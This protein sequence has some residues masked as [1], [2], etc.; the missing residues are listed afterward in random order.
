MA[1]LK[2][3]PESKT[4]TS[5]LRLRNV[6]SCACQSAC[7]EPGLG[8]GVLPLAPAATVQPTSVLAN[9]GG[10]RFGRRGLD[11]RAAVS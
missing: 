8:L 4:L 2:P 5:R 11:G 7:C 9:T 6:G 10:F 3:R 1:L